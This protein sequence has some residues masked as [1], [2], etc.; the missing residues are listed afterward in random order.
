MNANRPTQLLLKRCFGRKG[1]IALA[2][3]A[4]AGVGLIFFVHR[5]ST[6][7]VPFA[8]ETNADYINKLKTGDRWQTRSQSAL[9]LGKMP[10]FPAGIS[11]LIFALDDRDEVVRLRATMAL[12]TIGSP[13]IPD[14]VA[15]L[16]HE[17]EQ[18]RSQAD[19]AIAK[20]LEH[21]K[22]TLPDCTPPRPTPKKKRWFFSFRP[23]F[24]AIVQYIS[25]FR[26]KEDL[27]LTTNLKIDS[28]PCVTFGFEP[29]C[30]LKSLSR[31]ELNSAIANLTLALNSSNFT[32]D[33]RQ[34]NALASIQR[35]IAD[36]KRER[37]DRLREAIPKWL[38]FGIGS[39]LVVFCFLVPFEN[40]VKR[41]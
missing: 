17:R 34:Q 31:Q 7:Q 30:S 14:L 5:Q 41:N 9:K 18:V 24:L 12:I 35:A 28:S 8:A 29:T 4:I 3:I 15:G 25:I 27:D 1:K 13:A 21:E 23:K 19:F 37:Y 2:T 33:T 36:L 38:L 40:L 6:G 11:A 26:G 20:I 32:D 39:G 10:E 16:K 22:Q